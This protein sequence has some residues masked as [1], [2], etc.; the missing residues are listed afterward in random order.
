VNTDGRPA[1]T[2]TKTKRSTSEKLST[3]K[4]N[5]YVLREEYKLITWFFNIKHNTMEQ[6]KRMVS[7]CC[8]WLVFIMWCRSEKR[9][10]NVCGKCS[11]EC[12]I[13]ESKKP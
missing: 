5:N 12:K 7:A 6:L 1:S 13:T 9:N 8:G 4:A 10:K 2:P 11:K 3:E